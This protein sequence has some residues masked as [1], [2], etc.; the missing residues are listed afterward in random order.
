MIRKLGRRL[1][2]STGRTPV[3]EARPGA[4]ALAASPQTPAPAAA[5]DA[6]LLSVVVPTF[7]EQHN[8]P[9]LVARVDAALA[10][11]D[12][13]LVFVDDSTDETPEVI[14]RS[15]AAGDVRLIHRPPSEREGGL[16]TAI[17]CGLRAARGTYIAA[18]DADLQHPPEK[19]RELL[20][21]AQSGADVV[22]ASR[23]LRDGSAAGLPGVSRHIVS[24]GSKWLSRLLFYERLRQTSDPGSGFFLLRRSVIE[25][26]EL[27]P[28]GYKMLTEVLVRGRW[29]RL[30]EV[31]YRFEPR[32]AG[33]SKAGWW[34]G[35]QYLH[36]TYRMFVE[37]REVARLW[38]FLAVGASGVGVNLG[39]LWLST[40][41]LGVAAHPGWAVGVE[42]SILSNF[43]WNRTFTWRDRRDSRR[44]G[45]LRE[46]V[47]YH[48]ASV[49]GVLANFVA[50]SAAIRLGSATMPAGIAGIAA[51]FLANY[52]GAARFV[53]PASAG[54]RPP[55][56]AS[57][58]ARELGAG[59]DP[60]MLAAKECAPDGAR[61]DA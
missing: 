22:V 5:G 15:T 49:I 36:H 3:R 45:M 44:F 50:F 37:V 52:I 24:A 51:G 25:G 19:L 53:F 34:Q 30:A 43:W 8:V 17:V 27:R 16:T 13:E 20:A 40:S 28:V 35:I 54:L 10:G 29:S 21:A 38:K 46:A 31:P 39:L 60:P 26:V 14:A 59:D 55:A 9:T 4:G 12:F 47:R 48:I 56:A 7:N 6:P 18:I 58:S 2:W 42:G 61:S 57:A 33:Q 1:P 32:L 41:V 23:Y 11:I